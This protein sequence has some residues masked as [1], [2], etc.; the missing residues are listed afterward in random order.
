MSK[1]ESKSDKNS[2]Y[3]KDNEDRNTPAKTTRESEISLEKRF[4]GRK[5]SED[6][7]KIFLA[8]NQLEKKP[9]YL[10]G[11]EYVAGVS[12]NRKPILI[13]DEAKVPGK[14][15]DEYVLSYTLATYFS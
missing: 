14:G 4:L 2:N 11:R 13:F 5:F 8:G 1:R 10:N 12:K 6:E 9:A 7:F 15:K 3:Q